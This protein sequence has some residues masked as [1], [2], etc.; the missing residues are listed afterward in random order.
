MERTERRGRRRCNEGWREDRGREKREKKGMGKREEREIELSS[1][2]GR[3]EGGGE[4]HRPKGEEVWLPSDSPS[5]GSP[6]P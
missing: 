2:E 4:V 6:F 3:G 5:S 1:K